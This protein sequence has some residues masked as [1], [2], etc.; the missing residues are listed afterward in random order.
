MRI[1]NLAMDFG[2]KIWSIVTTW[3]N[4]AIDTI[5]KQLIKSSDSIAANLSEG[6]GRYHIKEIKHFCY[7]SR[8]SLFESKTWITKA[9]RRNLIDTNDYK[10]LSKDLK[11]LGIKLNNYIKVLGKNLNNQVK[12]PNEDYISDNEL[13]KL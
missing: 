13:D 11:D 2:E 10:T 5:G 7:I 8:G 6:F 4:L 3:N 9:N 1:Y 12:E